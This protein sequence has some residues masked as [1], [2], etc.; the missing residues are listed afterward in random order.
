VLIRFRCSRCRPAKALDSLH[1]SGELSGG[2]SS[3]SAKTSSTY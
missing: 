1:P 3:S 2:L